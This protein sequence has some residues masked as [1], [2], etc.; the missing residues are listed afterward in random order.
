MVNVACMELKVISS[1]ECTAWLAGHGIPVDADG[2]PALPNGRTT[3]FEI[4][5]DP[6]LQGVLSYKLERRFCG[7]TTGAST[8]RTRWMRSYR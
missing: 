1:V 6:A 8:R 5:R 3:V 4:A 2:T 7:C